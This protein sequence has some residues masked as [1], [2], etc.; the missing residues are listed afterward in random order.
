[1]ISFGFPSSHENAA[2]VQ[3]VSLSVGGDM[4]RTS[5]LLAGIDGGDDDRHILASDIGWMCGERDRPVRRP[6]YQADSIPEVAI[7]P[8]EQVSS[9]SLRSRKTYP[10]IPNGTTAENRKRQ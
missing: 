8:D 2:S 3:V 4:R 6:G 1:M 7:E 9:R 10:M 5:E